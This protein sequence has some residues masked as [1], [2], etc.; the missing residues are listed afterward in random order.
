MHNR[1][2]RISY[3]LF[4]TLILCLVPFAASAQGG[5]PFAQVNSAPPTGVCQIGQLALDTGGPTSLLFNTSQLYI[6]KSS[7][8]IPTGAAG[9]T[10]GGFVTSGLIA[11]Y[12]LDDGGGFSPRDVSGNGYNAS[13]CPSAPTWT[14][15]GLSFNSVSANCFKL[16]TTVPY[17]T[18]RTVEITYYE[19]P[20]YG[21]NGIPAN[22]PFPCWICSTN[23][24]GLVLMSLDI[25]GAN[26]QLFSG[27]RVVPNA[28]GAGA[29]TFVIT[30]GATTAWYIDGRETT[31]IQNGDMTGIFTAPNNPQWY[32]GW[33]VN[34]PAAFQ[35]VIS[36]VR[37]LNRVITPAEA[38]QDSAAMQNVVGSRGIKFGR[39]TTP[40]DA[41]V[42]VAHGDSRTVGYPAG[43]PYITYLNT[44]TNAAYSVY[45]NGTSG[46]KANVL[47]R[48]TPAWDCYQFSPTAPQN[49]ASLWEGT[50]DI[51][52]GGTSPAATWAYVSNDLQTFRNCGF[53]TI[54]A[55]DPSRISNDTFEQAYNAYIRPVW[56][57]VADGF[58]DFGADP[59]IG[60]TGCYTNTTWY[61]PDGI[62]FNATGYTLVAQMFARES[63]YLGGST[64][65]NCTKLVTST[66]YT[67]TDADGC[68]KFNPTGAS[69]NATFYN[70]NDFTGRIVYI[71]NS[72]LTGINT[73]T[74]TAAAGQTI[75]GAATS[76]VLNGALAIFQVVS[77]NG[78]APAG[79][80]NNLHRLQ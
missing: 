40:S 15:Q 45:D 56:Q 22:D 6:C 70:V 43:I 36:Y 67:L 10:S 29:H 12:P 39:Q 28:T 5:S 41:N 47:R 9:G 65:S 31:Y 76:I 71:Q 7:A 21:S 55:D 16:P 24:N 59:N 46:I 73:L 8:W 50:N 62:H 48:L 61:D 3:S 26:P 17:T 23:N 14:G 68:T 63:N 51:A 77:A 80:G 53:T 30:F 27:P 66:T 60:C 78:A 75:D 52:G 38:L 34:Y 2:R 1:P 18:V 57:T 72:Q 4:T 58:V 25:S 19:P 44:Y 49:I 20:S 11:S 79:A 33:S 54:V 69:V 35:G 42:W 13:F 37:L 64:F 32:V 74:V